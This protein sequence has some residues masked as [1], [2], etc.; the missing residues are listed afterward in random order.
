MYF[1]C[2]FLHPSTGRFPIRDN[3]CPHTRR[4]NI[5]FGI[6]FTFLEEQDSYGLIAAGYNRTTPESCLLYPIC[7]SRRLE[8][9]V[10]PQGFRAGC[11]WH[12]PVH[13][14]LA[15]L[16]SRYRLMHVS[17]E[18]AASRQHFYVDNP[19]HLHLLNV[20]FHLRT[21]SATVSVTADRIVRLHYTGHLCH[22]IGCPPW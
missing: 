22:D 17:Y 1:V 6:L 5:P 18:D 3:K 21:I 13:I 14:L 2:G 8:L 7:T 19:Q 9:I 11:E 4:C 12:S 16:C 10:I 15:I 20:G